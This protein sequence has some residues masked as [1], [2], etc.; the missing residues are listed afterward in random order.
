MSN[1]LAILNTQIRTLDNLYSLN[2]LHVASGGETKHRPSLFARNEQ[3]K[4]LIS[5]IEGSEN[6][7]STKTIFALKTIRGG[8]D[9]SLQGIWACEELVLAYAMWISPKFH[10][11]VLR[12]FL[13]MHKSQQPNLP[14]PAPEPTFN[15]NI[16]AFELQNLCWAAFALLRGAETFQELYPLFKKLGSNYSAEIYGQGFEYRGTIER[17]FATLKRLTTGIEADPQT[18]WRIL[19]HIRNFNPKSYGAITRKNP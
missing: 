16:T 12:A 6:E 8:K 11:V 5:E 19:N 1:Q 2:D 7:R 13:A 15:I 10:L 9:I 17:A 14:A 18:N 4:E 3:T